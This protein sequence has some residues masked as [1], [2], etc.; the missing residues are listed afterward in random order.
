MGKIY[1]IQ[2]YLRISAYYESIITG[3]ILEAKIKYIDPDDNEG[4]W[5]A[6]HDPQSKKFYYDVPA[7]LPLG[8]DGMWRAWTYVL[9]VDGRVLIGE[10]FKFRVYEE[11]R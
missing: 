8:K 1:D 3:D 5:D 4:E 2:T 11:G 7:G 10:M 6:V 9:F